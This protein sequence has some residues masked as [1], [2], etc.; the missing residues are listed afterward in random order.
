MGGLARTLTFL[1]RFL[2]FSFSLLALRDVIH[3]QS[4]LIKILP[5]S[6]FDRILE[7]CG[8]LPQHASTKSSRLVWRRLLSKYT[9]MICVK[10][11]ASHFSLVERIF[12]LLPGSVVYF[13]TSRRRTKLHVNIKT[14]NSFLSLIFVMQNKWCFWTHKAPNLLLVCFYCANNYAVL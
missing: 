10:Y 9:S 2:H 1:Y 13:D 7:L 11:Q 8:P 5:W 3:F 4:G 6:D 14:P 12:S